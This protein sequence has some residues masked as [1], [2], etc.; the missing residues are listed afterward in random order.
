MMKMEK[1]KKN[2]LSILMGRWTSKIGS[3]VFDYVN[4]VTLVGLNTKSSMFVA[5]YQS[6][7]TLI[8]LAMTM[9]AGVYADRV[10]K[11]KQVMIITDIISGLI[12]IILSFFLRDKLV[13]Y[14]IILANCL[15]A[16]V[17]M[18]NSPLYKTIVRHAI[19]R[20]NI[21]KVNSIANAGCE[22]LTLIGPII[23]VL[24]VKLV[25]VRIG[26]IFNG[27]T[28]LVSAA[29]EASIEVNT[30][31][32][33]V[34]LGENIWISLKNGIE[35]ILKNKELLKIFLFAGFMNFFIAG[36]N[37]FIPYADVIFGHN[38]NGMY[39]SI[40]IAQGI[41]AVIGSVVSVSM[42]K[43]FQGKIKRIQLLCSLVG[44]SLLLVPVVAQFDLPV[45]VLVPFAFTGFFTTI[46]NIQYMSYIQETVEPTYIGRVFGVLK[47]FAFLLV[48]LGA[49][50]FSATFGV[51]GLIGFTCAGVGIVLIS[52][53]GVLTK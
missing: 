15:L 37:V 36:C 29:I 25:G 30:D 23:G 9:I 48:P 31:N 26:L 39:A 45:L 44:A 7:E 35:Y 41:A 52:V 20:E 3:V 51:S 8:K 50:V 21:A 18:L 6:T 28:F 1:E 2:T 33:A 49:V 38:F 10:K 53:L 5:I 46:Y 17:E 42:S 43:I 22:G 40:V 11:K 16:I 47:T 32:D 24:L 4:N 27:I 34:G 19:K 13:A 14:I 12:C